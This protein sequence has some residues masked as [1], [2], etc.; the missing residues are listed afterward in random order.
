LSGKRVDFSSRTVISP[1]PNLG[2]EQVGIPIY[3][4]KTLTYPEKVNEYNIGRL[5]KAI[6]NGQDQHPGANIVR[7]AN[8]STVSLAF[9]NR[10]D[11]AA[12]LRVG[13]IVERHMDDGDIVLFNRQ[14]SLHKMSIMAH[15]VKVQPW[16][17]FRFNECVCT[18]YNADFDGDE[19]NLHL[20]QTEESRAE[21]AQL[22]SI[23]SNL[24]TPRNGE[25]LVAATQDFITAAYLVTHKDV[26]FDR[27]EFCKWI[28]CFADA[29]EQVDLVPPAIVKPKALWTGKQLMTML[30][31]PRNNTSNGCYVNLESK[32]K[33]YK[34]DDHFCPSEGFV[35]FRGG[36][37]LCGA[38][39][40]K[41]L[42]A[43]SKTGLFYVLIRDFGAAEATRCMARL[44][45]FCA[46][47]IGD[48]GFSIGIDDVTPSD[49]MIAQ[50][51]EQLKLGKEKATAEIELYN[52]K[53]IRLKPGC[54]AL[55]SF[56]SNVN[57]ILGKVRENCG[58]AALSALHPRNA[59]LTMA[60]CGSKGSPLNISQM[61]A[62]LGQQSVA[63]ARIQEGFVNRTLPHFPS[64]ALYPAAKGFVENSFYSGLT[65]T[66][67][68]FHTMGGREGLVDTAVKTAETGYMARRLMK[69]L[70]DLS[71][72]YD[73]TVRNSE[74]T[75]VQFKYGDDSLN[76]QDMEERGRPVDFSRLFWNLSINRKCYM[77]N[78]KDIDMANA[79]VIRGEQ[80]S[81]SMVDKKR[82]NGTNIKRN[83][84]SS[85]MDIQDMFD[86]MRSAPNAALGEIVQPHAEDSVSM[87][88][89]D[90]EDQLEMTFRKP[91]WTAIGDLYD[92]VD[93][94]QRIMTDNENFL[95]EI[96]D[97]FMEVSNRIK[98]YEINAGIYDAL[99]STKESMDNDKTLINSCVSFESIESI[100]SRLL[101]MKTD[102]FNK[103]SVKAKRRGTAEYCDALRLLCD[104][105]CRM[106]FRQFRMILAAAYHRYNMALI[107][108][109]EAV[110]AVGAQSLSEPGTQM[111][112]KT[113]HFAG[114]ASMNVTLGVPR[115][116]EIINASKSI[117]TPIIEARLVQ[118]DNVHSARIVKARI[119][120]TLLR[121]VV[122]YI[123]EV[124]DKDGGYILIKLCQETIDENT[125]NITTESVK[126]AILACNIDGSDLRSSTSILR[127]LKADNVDII[128][129][130]G[131][132]IRVR[133]PKVKEDKKR[134]KKT[135][136][137]DNVGE[138][139]EEPS[140][141]I[142]ANQKEDKSKKDHIP[143]TRK[144]YFYMQALKS[145][146]QHV[147][148]QGYSAVSR[149]VINEESNESDAQ[150]KNYYLLVEGY[151][152][153]EVMGCAG[154]DGRR[155]KSNHIIDMQE[156]LGIEAARYMITSEIRFIMTSYGITVDN[157]HLLLLSD[158]MTFKGEVLGITRF[159]VAKMRESVLML[160][161]FEKTTDHLFDA[162][163]HARQD[164][165]V[166]VSECIIM[167]V[168]IPI[169]TG[170][171]K[172]L[173]KAK[174]AVEVKKRPP[175]LSKYSM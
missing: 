72:Q 164:A 38:L 129:R 174:Q 137:K 157:R 48:R 57:G 52:T 124:H 165:I 152:L 150:T 8:R 20:P 82:A 156:V 122:E 117:S 15:R 118:E 2:I 105:T 88:S 138:S 49:E 99:Q 171:F 24:I 116:K 39:G 144:P 115:L 149:A 81:D 56:E 86:E 140:T 46:R 19:M 146:I 169:G 100:R 153:R 43:E 71:L 135:D 136:T 7:H 21:A 33:F 141:T 80:G 70:E 45:K 145:S 64:G 58:K 158:V 167:G 166:G 9:A 1:D 121:E 126:N 61:V 32:E 25:P 79:C 77:R 103:W 97:K 40:K 172:L 143:E 51:K 87:C 175:L 62:C 75:V 23:Q 69:A 14:P 89:L 12:K 120:K 17:T 85:K 125:L 78:E 63:G 13:D 53:Q 168:P 90:I 54:N 96:Q 151:G 41:T 134:K 10:E 123:K 35:L 131:D 73:N 113:F 6:L 94:N 108:P 67:F 109:G 148:V 76:P 66:E 111:T 95:R 119:E 163:V 59:A 31:R 18:P 159:G 68:F 11:T 93:F 50:K 84:N 127:A 83:T 28:A 104:T 4:A 173:H 139:T 26:F 5:K 74:K 133:T 29:N 55:Q 170:L 65:P 34:K 154:V 92:Q 98:G 162:A 142:E 106:T 110:G 112:L 47:Y 37:H 147:I 30:V 128:G 130:N 91:E 36:E 160:A 132:K 161:S 22:M 102:Q 107:Q 3:V 114:V 42:G 27:E 16:R 101:A 155:T 44:A 60:Q